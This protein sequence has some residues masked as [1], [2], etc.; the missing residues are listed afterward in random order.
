[1]D[2]NYVYLLDLCI[3]S[4]HL[5]SQTLIWPM[6]PYYEQW[7]GDSDSLRNSFMAKVHEVATP[8]NYPGLRGPSSLNSAPLSN[9]ELDPII[10][11]YSQINPW[12]PSVTR[13]N[14]EVEGWILYNT[15]REITDRI[16]KVYMVGYDPARNP[17]LCEIQ[18]LRPASV[19]AGTDWLYCFEGGT[20]GIPRNDKVPAWSMMGLVLVREDD[21]AHVLPGAPRPYDLYIVFRGSRSGDPRAITA[22][23]TERGNPDWVTDMDF[24]FGSGTVTNIPEISA[25]GSVS[26]GFAASV[27]T[28]LP[29]IIEC[30]EHIQANKPNAP[31]TIYVTGHSLGAALAVHFTSAVRLGNAY[32]C[33]PP[34]KKM[35]DKKMED[36]MMPAAIQGWP[37]QS[38]QLVPFALP[39]VGGKDFQEAFDI[40][41]RSCRVYLWGDPVAQTTR[42]YPVGNAYAIDPEKLINPTAKYKIGPSWNPAR[43]EPYNIRYYLIKDLQQLGFLPEHLP[44]GPFTQKPWKIFNNFKE[45][46]A[47]P[48]DGNANGQVS[49]ILGMNFNERLIQYLG[50]F[51]VMLKPGSQRQYIRKLHMAI[52]NANINGFDPSILPLY[53]EPKQLFTSELVQFFGLCLFLTQATKE[54]YARMVR[55]LTIRPYKYLTLI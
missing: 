27:H 2:C 34:P 20:G 46:L 18:A 26:P 10:S 4:Y 31:R 49:Q 22:L 7:L 11:D 48:W 37:W 14:R 42:G 16:N 32:W 6:D 44:T 41:V 29:T 13:P 1:M 28:M 40:T 54:T 15:P 39:V 38:T 17:L 30:L 53:D 24:G 52:S 36:S 21:A 33:P 8:A 35:R 19:P 9:R 3:F 47:E 55:L 45:V 23:T 51:E 50:V 5:H 25:I 12:R 43:H